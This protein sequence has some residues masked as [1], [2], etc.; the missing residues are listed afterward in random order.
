MKKTFTAASRAVYIAIVPFTVAVML[1]PAFLGAES[2]SH[3]TLGYDS[4]IDRFTILE[5]DTSESVQELYFGLGNALYYRNGKAKA[6]VN[7]LF[8]LGNQTIDESFDAEASFAPA[9]S[10][11]VDLRGGIHWRHFQEASDYEYGNDYIQ[12]NTILKVRKNIG[13][14]SRVTFKS[15]FELVDYEKKT[16]FDYDYRYFDGGAEIEAGPDFDKVILVGVSVGAREVPDTT[17]LSYDR[18]LAEL[19]ARVTSARGISFHLSSFGDRK[20]YRETIRSSSWNVISF[21]DMSFNSPSG[22]VY[23]LRTESEL[24]FFDRPD[25][26]YFDTRF[27]R[28]GVRVRY[29]IR[30]MSSIFIE[31]R[32][33]RMLCSSFEEERYWEASCVL[34]TD[35]MRNDKLWISF[36]YE[37]GYRDYTLDENDLYSDFYLNRISGMG[38]V[39]LPANMA[40]NLFVTHEPERHSRRADDFSVTLVSLDLSKRF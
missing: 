35:I 13:E 12:A 5:A 16:S 1:L 11:V 23:S 25:T 32:L 7:N 4:F 17:A 30:S 19:E 38:S 33:A 27:L 22:M 28:G 36:S 14:Y 34:G 9:K 24:T 10:A 26:I 2:R 15:R 31:P 6:G 40:F 39:S 37:P 3:V 21:L 8:R 18:L 29:P 20:D